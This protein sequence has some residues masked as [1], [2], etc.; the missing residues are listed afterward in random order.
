MPLRAPKPCY[1]I[2]TL[3]DRVVVQ[4]WKQGSR[5]LLPGPYVEVSKTDKVAQREEIDAFVKTITKEDE[6]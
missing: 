6:Q 1:R 3:K 2:Q 5:N 4:Y